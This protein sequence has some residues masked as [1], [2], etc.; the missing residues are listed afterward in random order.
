VDGDTVFA[1]STREVEFEREPDFARQL[2]LFV[3]QTAGAEAVRLAILDAVR[4][5]TAVT[6]PAGSWEPYPAPP[7]G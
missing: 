6:T 4:S 2:G 7:A 3:V 1:L 5:A